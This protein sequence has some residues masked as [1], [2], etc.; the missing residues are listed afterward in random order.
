MLLMLLMLLDDVNDELW[1]VLL[2]LSGHSQ[3]FIRIW[4]RGEWRD[5]VANWVAR[6]VRVARVANWVARHLV[7]NC[8]MG[9]Q[10][11]PTC[12]AEQAG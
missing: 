7:D 5:R 6:V 8:L 10:P 3:L 12:I 11:G 1:P 4:P 2:L 9:K